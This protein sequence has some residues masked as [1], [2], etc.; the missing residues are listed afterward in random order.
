MT[1]YQIIRRNQRSKCDT[2]HA[3]SNILSTKSEKAS[4]IQLKRCQ[5]FG[6]Q[7][8]RIKKTKKKKK[9][10]SSQFISEIWSSNDQKPKK[11]K[12]RG[13]YCDPMKTIFKFWLP[14]NQKTKRRMKQLWSD[15]SR[16]FL[17]SSVTT[18]H[19]KLLNWRAISA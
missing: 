6:S 12:E 1:D 4:V 8:T 9:C 14:K 18:W 3:I 2:V 11:K 7:M 10:N 13:C 16:D 15:R 5:R 17:I 19:I